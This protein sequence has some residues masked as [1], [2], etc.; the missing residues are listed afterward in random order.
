M[1]RF[2]LMQMFVRIYET[3]SL[4]EAARE[5]KTTQPTV[6]KRLMALER[7][8]GARLFERNTRGL[9]PTE[10]GELYYERSKRW[11]AEMEEVEEQIATARRS[12]R[13][14]LRVS[15]PVNIGQVQLARI[16]FAF[17]HKHPG[18]QVELSLSDRVV[19]L[20]KESV[21]VA[22]RSGRVTA[23][24]VVAKKLASY[25]TIFVAAPSYIERR[26][27]PAS[28]NELLRHRLLY[29]AMRDE[30]VFWRG[31]QRLVPRDPDLFVSDALALREAV[32]EGIALGLLAPW[33]VEKD[34][35]RGSLVR[36]LPEAQGE[37]FD[38]HAVYLPGK[39]LP[40]RTRAFI[41]HV[42][43]E[44]PRISGMEPPGHGAAHPSLTAPTQ[45]TPP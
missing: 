16:V 18:V 27:L 33:L 1:D 10:A 24:N 15:V 25:R 40:A 14:R 13:G 42:T 29:H 12:A 7:A 44:V 28:L 41:A 11:L 22:I 32:R 4:S 36:V 17:Q 26:G 35:A 34:L 39:S 21:D 31:E 43:S 8:L 3:Q 37:R 23:P 5:L 20:V 45:L 38:V 30:T 2:E 9:S 19:D 6:S